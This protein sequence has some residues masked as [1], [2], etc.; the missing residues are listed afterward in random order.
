MI[1]CRVSLF[2]IRVG[3]NID[4][5]PGCH[6]VSLFNLI[7]AFCLLC[8]RKKTLFHFSVSPHPSRSGAHSSEQYQDLTIPVI[9]FAPLACRCRIA[10]GL[11]SSEVHR[12]ET[13]PHE[14]FP[15]PFFCIV[16]K[17]AS[18]YLPPSAAQVSCVD[19]GTTPMHPNTLFVPLSCLFNVCRSPTLWAA[20][21]NPHDRP[22]FMGAKGLAMLYRCRYPRH[23]S[24]LA[25]CAMWVRKQDG[26]HIVVFW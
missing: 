24:D 18:V 4:A 10:I 15:Y 8:D 7:I 11:Q 13:C 25:I 3:S 16:G 9:I 22:H 21:Y 6:C 19:R 5:F 2:H 26:I 14:Y 23:M 12:Q 1:H 20:L 17:I